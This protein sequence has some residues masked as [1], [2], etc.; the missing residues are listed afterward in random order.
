LGSGL[1]SSQQEEG[2]SELGLDKTK[3]GEGFL[4]KG[5]DLDERAVFFDVS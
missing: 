4:G 1:F 5:V 2:C 3:A